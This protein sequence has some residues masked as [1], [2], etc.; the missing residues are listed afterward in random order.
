MDA[1]IVSTWGAIIVSVVA[2]V[3]FTAALVVAFFL[4]DKSSAPA[5]GRCGDR[6]R[7]N[8][9]RVLAWQFLRLAE[10]R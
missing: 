2:L 6:K 1:K 4:N 5:H 3:T 8:R 10:E 9:N 7:Y